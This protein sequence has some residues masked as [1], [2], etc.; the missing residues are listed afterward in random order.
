MQIGVIGEGVVGAATKNGLARGHELLCYDKYKESTSSLKEI[1]EKCSVI[2]LT[3][4]TPMK[5]SG[6]IDLSAIYESVGILNEYMPLTNSVWPEENKDNKTII[7]I[8][9]TAVSGTTD[10]L[11]EKYPKF[12]FA[13]N[14]EFLT[15]KNAQQ[16]FLDSKR[17]VIGANSDRVFEVLKQVYIDAKFTCPIIRT[18]VKTAEYIKYCSNIFLASQ[19]STSNE[20]YEIAQLLG[21]NWEEIREALSHDERIGKF[22][23]VPGHDLDR[24][25]GGKC[26]CKDLNALIY[27]SREHGYRPGLLEEIWRTN[28]KF[29]TKIDW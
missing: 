8:R 4:P 29:R 7:V 5:K 15:D 11:A 17:I 26:L 16:D 1:A 22:T 12:D 6:E 24:G 10:K 9:S 21:I 13:F 2:F 23:Q 3:V 27:L 25:F 18:D 28:L 14:P 20:L 19:I